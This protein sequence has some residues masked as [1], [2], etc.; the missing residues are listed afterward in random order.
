MFR[1][2]PL[3]KLLHQDSTKM[4]EPMLVVVW[5]SPT[6]VAV[7]EYPFREDAEDKYNELLQAHVPKV[8]LAKI[9]KSHG[10]G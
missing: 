9:I 5:T 2:G 6:A 10:E 3:K 4:Y 1:D 7:K 8:V